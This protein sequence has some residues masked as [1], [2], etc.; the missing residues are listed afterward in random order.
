MIMHV[1]Q[2]FSKAASISLWNV[3]LPIKTKDALYAL[4]PLEKLPL[5]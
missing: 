2:A 1:K 4:K 3:V 5:Y